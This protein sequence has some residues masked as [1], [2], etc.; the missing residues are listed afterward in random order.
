MYHVLLPIDGDELRV[1]SQVDAILDLQQAGDD[2]RV[3]ILYVYEEIDVAPD[4]AG[5]STIDRIN[6]NLDDLQGL[7]DTA[8]LAVDALCEADIET[9]IHDVIG[10]PAT[11]I[12][13]VA[14]DYDVDSIVVG[15]RRR[16]PVGK[17]VFGSVAQAVILGADRT[18]VVAS[19]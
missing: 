11:A 7:P 19:P 15:A 10:D 12:V 16:S 1:R 18:V 2:L 6:E 5:S 13:D 9:D 17:A 14:D 8:D 4:E 3:D